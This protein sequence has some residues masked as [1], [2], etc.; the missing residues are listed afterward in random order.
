MANPSRPRNIIYKG[1]VVKSA[2]FCYLLQ[3]AA[4]ILQQNQYFLKNLAF[5]IDIL[6]KV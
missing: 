3:I 2:I 5:A 6:N 4:K 1:N